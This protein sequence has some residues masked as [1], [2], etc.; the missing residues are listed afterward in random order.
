MA[1]GN[2]SLEPPL[3]GLAVVSPYRR[4]IKWWWIFWLAVPLLVWWSM[5]GLEL[6]EIWGTVRHL[7]GAA[8]FFLVLLN[9]SILV[10]F[11]SRWWL[12]LHAQGYRLPYLSLVAYR[13]AGFG[14]TYFTPGTQ[15]G[16]EPL[17]VHLLRRRDRVPSDMAIASVGLDKLLELLANFTFLLVGVSSVLASGL[18]GEAISR[19]LLVLPILLL[20]LPFAYLAALWLGQRPAAS[21]SRRLAAR[22]PGSLLLTRAAHLTPAAEDNVARFFHQHPGHLLLAVLAS[23]FIWLAII[24]EFSLMLRFLG[25]HLSLPQVMLA[26]TAARLAFLLPVPAGLGSLEAGQVLAMGLLGVNPAV[27]ISLSLVIRARDLF[28]GGAGLWIGAVLSR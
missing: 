4:R 19:E 8:I 10:L 20:A 7:G 17:Q 16:G 14:V 15:L 24:L 2:L 1:D 22:F 18:G 11:A 13:L 28:F 21:L 5:R 3:K 6:A 23:L 26:L 12:I 25:L 9:L 27:A